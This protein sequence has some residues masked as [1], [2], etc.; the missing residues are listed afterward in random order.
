MH[1]IIYVH[2]GFGVAPPDEQICLFVL[3][4]YN[5]TSYHAPF[6]Y[7]CHPADLSRFLLTEHL[8]RLHKCI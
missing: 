8:Q 4:L 7:K 6:V 2:I 1:V 3:D 5:Y